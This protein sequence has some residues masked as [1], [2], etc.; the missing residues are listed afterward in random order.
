MAAPAYPWPSTSGVPW[1]PDQ[2]Y[3]FTGTKGTTVKQ[4]YVLAGD[5]GA[6]VTDGI[7]NAIST[8]NRPRR[9]G[10]TVATGWNPIAMDVPVRFTADYGYGPYN[11]ENDIASLV[12]MAGRGTAT[13]GTDSNFVDLIYGAMS[14]TPPYVQLV[15][16]NPYA[17]PFTTLLPI[18][19][20][21]VFSWLISAIQFAPNP[22]RQLPV[23]NNSGGRL[24]QDATISLI[25]YIAPPGSP[26]GPIQQPVPASQRQK[27]RNTQNGYRTYTSTTGQDTIQKI[28]RAHGLNT[29]TAWTQI[30][31]YNMDLLGGRSWLQPLKP[32][33]KVR[34]PNDLF[35]APS[36]GANLE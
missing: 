28:A 31:A 26:L 2:V 19:A 11:V 14:G 3:F 9:V 36:G 8:I 6:T 21:T 25:Q 17:G 10:F 30:T 32:G 34:I 7:A 12:W 15:S 4:F 23:N 29:A 1:T 16:A 13:T 20:S 22:V 5:G 27:Q 18:E 35:T 24:R 33:T